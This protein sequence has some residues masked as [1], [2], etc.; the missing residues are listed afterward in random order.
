MH[1]TFKSHR[2][3]LIT[4]VFEHHL[5]AAGPHPRVSDSA[6]LGGGNPGICIPD[7]YPLDV[8]C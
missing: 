3:L 5:G 2:Y 1:K 7:R 8:L 6:G 4:L